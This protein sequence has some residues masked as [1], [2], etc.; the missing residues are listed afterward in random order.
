[1]SDA[2]EAIASPEDGMGARLRSHRRFRGLTLQELGDRAGLSAGF[3]S[4]VERGE[5]SLDRRSHQQSLA[6][7]LEIS[8]SDLVGTPDTRVDPELRRAEAAVPKLRVALLEADLDGP[9]AV[10][11]RPLPALAEQ[12]RRVHGAWDRYDLATMSQS[13]APLILE[14]HA[15]TRE[16]V[17]ADRDRALR[18]LGEAC[19]AARAVLRMLGEIDLAWLA[20]QRRHRVGLEAG[21]PSWIAAGEHAR[22]I[23]LTAAG[24]AN[25]APRL[26]VRALDELGSRANAPMLGMLHLATALAFAR[27]G[28]RTQAWGHLDEAAC[29]AHGAVPGQTYGLFHG[30]GNV[31]VER[32]VLA[33]ELGDPDQASRAAQDLGEQ[34]MAAL[35][36]ARRVC[37]HLAY[38]RAL[39]AANATRQA[40]HQF[41]AAERLAPQRVHADVLA[42]DAVEV[43]LRRAPRAGGRDLRGLAAR[44]GLQP[45]T[46]AAR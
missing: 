14:A 43:L 21:D 23:T 24:A 11:A 27:A 4:R 20:A 41:K 45:R 15:A 33:M 40:V 42:R 39:A 12:T 2:G 19:D 26:G 18:L 7:A 44:L 37:A 25:R 9:S 28:E 16:S 5:R 38:G 6:D 30:P 32:M 29:L 1:M 31:L 35:P 22:I 13:L 34:G 36:R 8:V 10:R 17:G 3:L 46:R